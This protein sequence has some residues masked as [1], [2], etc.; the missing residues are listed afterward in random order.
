[1]CSVSIA[2]TAGTQIQGLVALNY[3]NYNYE[4]W[5]GIMLTIAVTM[6]GANITLARKLPMIEATILVIHVFAFF[7][8][9]VP[10]WVLSPRGDMESIFTQFSNG[11][12]WASL[13]TSALVGLNGGISKSHLRQSECISSSYTSLIFCTSSVTLTGADS[14]V[15]MSEEIQ[16]A[17][18]NIPRSMIATIIVNGAI[19]TRKHIPYLTEE[20]Y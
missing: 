4:A 20:N 11:G 8:I 18:V 9:L 19:G 3:P 2:F 10:L 1:M 14:V 17:S 16:Q 13:G 6:F 5:H 12:D 15:H 7:G